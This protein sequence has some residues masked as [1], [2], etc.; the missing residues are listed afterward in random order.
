MWFRLKSIDMPLL[1]EANLQLRDHA[2]P[3]YP[4]QSDAH[5]IAMLFGW[6]GPV[7]DKNAARK[8]ELASRVVRVL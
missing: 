5:I 4:Q 2:L 8:L 1:A 6:F 3:G 7:L